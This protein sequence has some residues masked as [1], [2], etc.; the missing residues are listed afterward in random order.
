MC[1]ASEFPPNP[2]QEPAE[3]QTSTTL[4]ANAFASLCYPPVELE[5]NLLTASSSS[6]LIG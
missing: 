1:L 3:A 2:L 6:G 4:Q 5:S